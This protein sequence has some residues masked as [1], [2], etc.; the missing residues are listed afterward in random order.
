MTHLM[1][2]NK[3]ILNIKLLELT[4]IYIWYIVNFPI[5]INFS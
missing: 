1:T 4:K 2:S 3:K 5:W